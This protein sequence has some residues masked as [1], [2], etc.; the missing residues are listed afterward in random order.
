[1]LVR[2]RLLV[3]GIDGEDPVPSSEGSVEV[4]PA[5]R[6]QSVAI[7]D[8][9]GLVLCRGKERPGCTSFGDT[10]TASCRLQRR[11]GHVGGFKIKLTRAKPERRTVPRCCGGW[12]CVRGIGRAR[13]ELARGRARDLLSATLIAESNRPASTSSRMAAQ[14][15]AGDSNVFCAGGLGGSTGFAVA[16]FGGASGAGLPLAKAAAFDEAVMLAEAVVF[17]GAMLFAAALLLSGTLL[18]GSSATY[19]FNS[20]LARRDFPWSRR[21]MAS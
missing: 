19:A 18:S 6:D 14:A 12:L 16:G 4:L 20:T 10:A 1:M 13:A 2:L 17:A 15:S 11:F 8:F 5:E 7:I 9:D 3:I 21:S